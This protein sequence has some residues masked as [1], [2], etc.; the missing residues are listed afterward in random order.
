M[1]VDTAV[2]GQIGVQKFTQSTIHNYA[3]I[4][5][6]IR[7]PIMDGYEA[8]KAIR[9]LKRPDAKTVPIIALSAN[10]FA[11]D[12][13]KSARMGMNGHLAK[14]INPK[15]LYATLAKVMHK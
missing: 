5:M 3:A 1:F 10:A 11:E 8:T 4:L 14:P 6:D 12:V 7:M 15:M 9:Q 13:Q 2:D